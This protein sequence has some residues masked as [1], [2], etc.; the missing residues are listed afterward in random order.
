VIEW[1]VCVPC[2]LFNYQ[3]YPSWLITVALS[4]EQSNLGTAK[5]GNQDGVSCGNCP[6]LQ[7]MSS[8]NNFRHNRGNEAIDPSSTLQEGSGLLLKAPRANTV[9]VLDY[10][11]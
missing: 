11:K 1:P 3:F 9:E 6:Q 5:S 7:V 8:N 4:R 10:H 2:D